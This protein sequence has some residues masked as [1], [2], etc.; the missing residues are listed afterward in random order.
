MSNTKLSL[1]RWHQHLGQLN[2]TLLK[3][4]LTNPNIIFN[5]NTEKYVCDS[6]KKA[7]AMK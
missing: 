3:K 5:D 4:H 2:F 6:C 1:T 7:K